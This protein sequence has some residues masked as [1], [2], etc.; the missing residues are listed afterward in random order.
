MA[1]AQARMGHRYSARPG[2]VAGGAPSVSFASGPAFW[3]RSFWRRNRLRRW[4]DVG[5]RLGRS[6]ERY[7][8]QTFHGHA[9]LL[10]EFQQLEKSLD[11]PL[12]QRKIFGLHLGTYPLQELRSLR[13]REY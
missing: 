3:G 8:A 1:W 7:P 12:D 5:G 6:A 2:V 11:H 13:F 9:P 10:A 4:E